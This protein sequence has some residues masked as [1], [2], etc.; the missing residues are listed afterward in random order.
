MAILLRKLTERS[1]M[2]FGRFSEQT[3]STLLQTNKAYLRWVYYNSSN[4]SF[5]PEVLHELGIESHQIQKPGK[6]PL[7]GDEVKKMFKDFSADLYVEN[8]VKK[9]KRKN[10]ARKMS[11]QAPIEF[12]AFT[13]TRFSK[14]NGGARTKVLSGENMI[15]A[16]S[17]AA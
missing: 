13:T 6:N 10:T 15:R 1:K 4:I 16:H 5:M 12:S 2:G 14:N 11:D 17:D 3:V 9:C 7:L 8:N